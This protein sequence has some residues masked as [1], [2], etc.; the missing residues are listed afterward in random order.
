MA[1][2]YITEGHSKHNT[3][4]RGQRDYSILPRSPSEALSRTG[5]PSRHAEAGAPP[6]SLVVFFNRLITFLLIVSI[7][8]GGAVLLRPPPVRCAGSARL[9]N[10]IRRG[11]TAKAS[12]AIASGWSSDG[13]IDDRWTFLHRVAVTSRSTIRSKL[14]NMH[15]KVNASLRDILDTLVEGKSILYSVSIPEGLTSYQIV[16]R[17]KADTRILAGDIVEVPPEGSLLAGHLSYREG[18]FARRADPADA[19]QAE[20][21]PRRAMVHRVRVTCKPGSRKTSSIS[22]RSWRRR[23]ARRMNGLA[24]R[25]FIRT[26]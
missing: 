3:A 12:S 6:A 10:G 20:E 1:G 8:V 13:I 15:I 7:C 9:P 24:S 11:A 26:G 19:G 25:R 18:Y 14:A 2:E 17:L 21:I 23:R 5:R 16:E 22:R 4:Y